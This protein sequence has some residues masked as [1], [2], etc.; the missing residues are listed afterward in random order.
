MMYSSFTALLFP[1][2]FVSVSALPQQ[3]GS[4]ASA[5]YT[6]DTRF[7]ETVLDVTNTYRKQHNA[8]ALE[9][10]STLADYAADWSEDC[11]FKHSGGSY[12]EN[13]ASGYANVTDSIV[14]WGQEREEY[15]F[16]GGEF[17]TSTGHFTQ[18]VWRNT[19]QVG[20]SRTQC[21]AGQPGG[22]GD[23]PGWYL[24][25]EYSPAGN[26]ISEFVDNVQAALPASEQP[27]EP[28][29]PGVPSTESNA[30]SSLQ[31]PKVALW[32]AIS[33][34]CLSSWLV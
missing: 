1:S 33:A 23:A 5:E 6:D 9:W 19:T 4:E 11:E 31:G 16:E 8:T 25:C 10:N 30:A 27:A 29:A 7:R 34:S 28:N 14:G 12:G 21:N 22:E 18:L 2:L 20:C 32:I 15:D 17:S 26:V 13:L 24:V 3:T